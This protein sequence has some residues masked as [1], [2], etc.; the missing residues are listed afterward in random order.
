[1]EHK[2]S[3]GLMDDTMKIEFNWHWLHSQ[4][5]LLMSHRMISNQIITNGKMMIGDLYFIWLHILDRSHRFHTHF[6]EDFVRFFSKNFLQIAMILWRGKKW[7]KCECKCKCKCIHSIVQVRNVMVC[8]LLLL[9]WRMRKKESICHSCRIKCW[10]CKIGKTV[11]LHRS[12]TIFYVQKIS[13][14]WT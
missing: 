13:L 14:T 11:L 10:K 1:M 7:R 4:D 9:F 12:L 6:I 2:I 3:N 5:T 8:F